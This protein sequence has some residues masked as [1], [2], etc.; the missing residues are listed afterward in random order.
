M[1]FISQAQFIP[2][3]PIPTISVVVDSVLPIHIHTHTLN[4]VNS[5]PTSVAELCLIFLFVFLDEL[6]L[7]VLR[8]PHSF[9]FLCFILGA[10]RQSLSR[11]DGR[12]AGYG[13]SGSDHC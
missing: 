4:P 2:L 11:H 5:V 7:T 1:S 12:W 3:Q 9:S 6:L 8:E 13:G 10:L